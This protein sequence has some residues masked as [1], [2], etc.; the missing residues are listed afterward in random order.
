MM[1]QRRALFP[2]SIDRKIVFFLMAACALAYC[3]LAYELILAKLIAEMTGNPLLWENLSMGSFLL[4]LGAR[5]LVE[6]PS[7]HRGAFRELI[8]TEICIITAM[9]VSVLA[10][11]GAEIFYRIYIYS[12]GSGRSLWPFP[13]VWLLGGLSQLAP[14]WVGWLSSFELLFFLHFK[15]GTFIQRQ[16]AKV[17]A[18]Y[19]LGALVAT[20]TFPYVL[21]KSWSP[22]EMAG[23]VALINF[24]LLTSLWVFFRKNIVKKCDFA[25]NSP[26]F[27]S[28]FMPLA[29]IVLMFFLS[30]SVERLSRKNFYHNRLSW[31]FDTRGIYDYRQPIGYWDL[32]PAMKTKPD[33]ERIR[34]PYQVID[35]IREPKESED[36]RGASAGALH[37]NGRFQIDTN[38][39]RQ[40]HEPMVHVAMGLWHEPRQRVLILGG[41]DGALARELRRYDATI[42][43]AVLVDI[44]AQMIRLAKTEPFLR[45]INGD[46][47]SW[48]K[49]NV[50][51]GDAMSYL[52]QK[53]TLFDAIFLDLTY[54]YE[55][56]SVRFYSVEFFRLMKS[57]LG[58]SGFFVLGS[59][60]DLIGSEH[61]KW[62]DILYSTVHAAG[63][64]EQIAVNGKLDHFLIAS[65]RQLESAPSVET[66]R[67]LVAGDTSFIH[68]VQVKRLSRKIRKDLINSVMR[69]QSLGVEDTFF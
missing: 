19:H 64:S 17:L 18:T 21:L 6:K 24:A 9:V 22:V 59:P 62:R 47:L 14:F 65:T 68:D 57:R 25:S 63:Y 16:E 36:Q 48:P 52:R 41:G 37:I 58:P 29:A 55:F 13:P 38:T 34:T 39:S 42:K 20:L 5:S 40:Y 31:V 61:S 28:L 12:D 43:E 27:F 11:F 49:L 23:S 3:S 15:N 51:V 46:A 45:Q 50:V 44:D 69:P 54:P 32:M 35:V 60:V 4:G 33:V 1:D 66:L 67:I 10:I 56:D 26:S 7:G 8:H 53:G 2:F 30:P